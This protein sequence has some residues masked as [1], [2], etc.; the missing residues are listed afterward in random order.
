VFISYRVATESDFAIALYNKLVHQKNLRVFLDHS[1]TE[2]RQTFLRALSRST[3]V[4]P[5]IS[6]P[7]VL[8]PWSKDVSGQYPI[9]TK[10][11]NLLIEHQAALGFYQLNRLHK[12]GQ[13]TSEMSRVKCVLPIFIGSPNRFDEMSFRL[14]GDIPDVVSVG[15]QSSGKE[16]CRKTGMVFAESFFDKTIYRLV[17]RRII[18]QPLA[19]VWISVQDHF[20]FSHSCILLSFFLHSGVCSTW[21]EFASDVNGKK[22]SKLIGSNDEEKLLDLCNLIAEQVQEHTKDMNWIRRFV[23]KFLA[24]FLCRVDSH[25]PIPVVCICSG[26]FAFLCGKPLFSHFSLCLLQ[27]TAG[28]AV[29]VCTTTL[30]PVAISGPGQLRIFLKNQNFGG[31][32]RFLHV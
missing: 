9:T 30:S 21:T 2:T 18:H 22:L 13:G 4:V 12:S 3:V 15:T 16:L 7:G 27:N 1:H 20:T 28:Y 31:S 25:G 14:S 29:N 24:N 10:A 32:R 26:A 6:E 5:F 23:G 11:D 17:S 19:L 8:Q